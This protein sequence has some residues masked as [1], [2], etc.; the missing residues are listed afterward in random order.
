MGSTGTTAIDPVA[1]MGELARAHGA[2]L[3]VDAA[4]AGTAMAC[5]ELR[6]M[7]EGVEQAD[8]VVWN[9]HKWLGIGFDCTAYHVR[10]PD[11]LVR[12]PHD[13]GARR[14]FDRLLTELAPG[15][16]EMVEMPGRGHALIIDSGWQEVADTALAFVQHFTSPQPA[17]TGP[18]GS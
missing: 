6:W 8:S 18:A 17:R 15:V 1:R 16:T 14:A 2:W 10:D 4:M 12:V 3:H 13:R 5:P 7:W 11:H 9:P